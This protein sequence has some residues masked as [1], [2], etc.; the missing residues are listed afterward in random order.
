[1]HSGLLINLS[2]DAWL[3]VTA[4]ALSLWR[5]ATSQSRSTAAGAA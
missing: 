5:R 1:M 2:N 4:L 3:A